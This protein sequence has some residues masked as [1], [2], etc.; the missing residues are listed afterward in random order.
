M[1]MP[2]ST[3]MTSPVE[4][5]MST[6]EQQ[7]DGAGDVAGLSPAAH[8]RDA[9]GEQ[10]VVALL[11]PGGHVGGDHAGAN[12]V[13]DDALGR[14]P[15]GPQLGRHGHARLRQAVFATVQRHVC[16]RDRR[17]VDDR[18]AGPFEGEGIGVAALGDHLPGHRLGEEV[19]AAQVDRHDPVVRLRA[20]VEDVVAHQWC[21]AGVVHEVV[22]ASVGVQ[23]RRDEALV[24]AG[25][26]DTALHVG[27]LAEVA[28]G[29]QA[30]RSGAS[31]VASTTTR[32]PSASSRLVIPRPMPRDP[33]VTIVTGPLARARR[34]VC[35]LHGMSS[36]I[37]RRG[38]APHLIVW[39]SAR[40]GK[41]FPSIGWHLSLSRRFRRF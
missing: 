32:C 21:D 25:V 36:L 28:Q 16:G 40:M 35:R 23:G 24:I 22:D 8:R 27:H 30:V 18:P 13:D 33:P 39:D 41:R 5:G 34:V 3:W 4:Y 26:G 9:L 31:R 19:G 12:L 6:G 37:A 11:D 17:H 20:G 10:C 15:R 29:R 38:P 1:C 14:E 7:R 2:P